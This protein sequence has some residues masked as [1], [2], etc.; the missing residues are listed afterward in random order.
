MAANNTVFFIVFT[1]A[2]VGLYLT[3]KICHLSRAALPV[4]GRNGFAGPRQS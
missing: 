3:K 2:H 1:P 4:L